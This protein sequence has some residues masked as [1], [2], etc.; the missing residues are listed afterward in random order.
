MRT[1]GVFLIF[2]RSHGRCEPACQWSSSFVS[3]AFSRRRRLHRSREI[4]QRCTSV[5]LWRS[6]TSIGGQVFLYWERTTLPKNFLIC[7]GGVEVVAHSL[8]HVLE[9]KAGS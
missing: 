8:R 3:S 5:V 4:E 9:R 2:I 6:H 7:P 1:S